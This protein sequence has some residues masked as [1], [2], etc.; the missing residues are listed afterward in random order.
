MYY[1][2]KVTYTCCGYH[3]DQSTLEYNKPKEDLM[4]AS[5]AT[6]LPIKHSLKPLQNEAEGY[7]WYKHLGYIGKDAIKHLL[8]LVT[9]V[10]LKGLT[11]VKYKSYGVNKTYKVIFKR[12]LT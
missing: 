11:M 9:G 8:Q 2:D 5:F 3:C 4:E 7:I 10:L 12:Q 1:S 6:Q